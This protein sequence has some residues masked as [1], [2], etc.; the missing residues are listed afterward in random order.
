MTPAPPGIPERFTAPLAASFVAAYARAIVP[1]LAAG[2][3]D[4]PPQP[5]TATT[6]SIAT[7][8]VNPVLTESVLP[9][10]REVNPDTV[11]FM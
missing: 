2:L 6:S 4:P 9:P 3:L 5:A 7:T 10:I 11:K 8:P 1:R